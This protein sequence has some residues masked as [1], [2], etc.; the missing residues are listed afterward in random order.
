MPREAIVEIASLG[1]GKLGARLFWSAVDHPDA[2]DYAP[3]AI[4]PAELPRLD[5]G[6]NVTAYGRALREALASHQAIAHELDEISLTA[7]PDRSLLQ[8]LIAPA[9]GERLRWETLC[10]AS[11]NFLALNGAC[12]VSRIAHT[13]AP[14]DPGMRTFTFPL[15]MAAFLSAAKIK[16]ADEFNAICARVVQARSEGFQIV[17]TVYLG[18]QELLEDAQTR[19]AQ[20]K[21]PGIEVR[22]MPA[23][24]LDVEDALKAHPVEFLHFFCHG[25]LIEPGVRMLE[26]ATISDHDLERARGSVTL[27]IERLT[28][29]LLATG[30]TWITVLNSCSGG[31]PVEQ[32]HSMALTLAK[33]ASPFV[34][35]MAEEVA[36]KDATIVTRELYH[37]LFT[38]VRA[39]VGTLNVGEKT[40]LD[41]APAVIRARVALRDEYNDAASDTYGR[42]SIPLLYRRHIPLHVLR[43]IEP[44]MKQRIEVVAG[45]LRSLPTDTPQALREQILATLES[46]GVPEAQRP[47]AF[48]VLPAN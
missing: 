28:Q 9:E 18:E 46:A 41:L 2:L 48:G 40:V 35:G 23:Q 25:V 5:T 17:C 15:R 38:I 31:H 39:A 20:G 33:S 7:S 32:L 42:W 27:S 43:G 13:A 45:M 36:E 47:N 21:L 30:T 1:K 12:T 37:E 8:F 3:I 4:V 19:I 24:S 44:D 29:V 6:A 34:V 16:A 26:L 14:K 22:P 11:Q 10:S